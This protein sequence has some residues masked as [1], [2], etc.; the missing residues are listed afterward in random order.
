MFTGIIEETGTIK[1]IK[2]DSNSAYIRIGANIVLDGTKIGDSIAV[3]GACQTVV[4]LD[5]D[6]FDIFSSYETLNKTT[7]GS[8]NTNAT[9]NLERALRLNDRLGGHI[10]TGH[11]DA[12]AEMTSL[13]KFGDAVE[14]TF[15]APSAQL[16][17]IVKKGSVTIDGISLTVAD[18][19][20]GIFTVAVIPHTFE[21]TTLK[22]IKIGDKV[23]L[24]TDLLSKYVE[25]YLSPDHNNS[26]LDF[27]FLKENGFI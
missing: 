12:I 19:S 16:K 1:A 17:Q 8:L 22:K 10:V 15:C 24:E 27:D 9:V 4:G 6:W 23:N 26:T 20:K 21:N 18:V 3:N 13:K 5:N 7:L 25:K 11:V 14:M 2:K